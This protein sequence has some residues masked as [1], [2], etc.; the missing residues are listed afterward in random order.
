MRSVFLKGVLLTKPHVVITVLFVVLLAS[1]WPK[2]QKP[3]AKKRTH[4]FTYKNYL[5]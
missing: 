3:I 4:S 2:N 1:H 5:R